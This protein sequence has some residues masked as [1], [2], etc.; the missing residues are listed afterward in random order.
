MRTALRIFLSAGLVAALFSSAP[1]VS[2]AP[3]GCASQWFEVYDIQMDTDKEVYRLGDTATVAVSVTNAATGA[4]V[5]NAD[6]SVG[7]VV[8][9]DGYYYVTK[10]V[11]TNASGKATAKLPLKRGRMVPG[12]A[13]L[14]GFAR[15][16]YDEGDPACAGIGLYGYGSRKRAFRIK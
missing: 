12:W 3:T 8:D 2:A 7:A 16:Y 5:Q 11:R 15:T 13:E 10:A 4:P 9:S 14:R 6:V 1:S